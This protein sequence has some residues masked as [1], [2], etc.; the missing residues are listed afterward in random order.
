MQ[1]N[2]VKVYSEDAENRWFLQ[3]LVPEFLSCV[4]VLDVN[5]SL[6]QLISLYTEDVSYFG[7]VL[8]VLNGNEN[9]EVIPERLRER[10]KNI[11]KLPGN[12]SLEKMLCNYILSLPPEHPYWESASKVD[13][14]WTYFKE[15]SPD[16]S[17][18]RGKGKYKKWFNKHKGAFE[19][20][21]LFDFWAN[22]NKDLVEDFKKNFVDSYNA[23]ASRVFSS[24]I[25]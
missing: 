6:D 25:K 8:I 24:I 16:S 2:K 13:M 12:E 1:F 9:L 4:D 14:S 23:I 18:Y 21:K 20:T 11:I 17:K 10:F 15:N 22:D 7:N 19:L 5:L 3:K